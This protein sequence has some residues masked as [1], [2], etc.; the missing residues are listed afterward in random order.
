MRLTQLFTGEKQITDPCLQGVTDRNGAY[1]QLIR[2]LTPG[3]IL[4]GEILSKDGNEVQVRLAENGIL[5]ARLAANMNLEVGKSMTFEVK[6]NGQTLVLSPLFENTATDA[7]VFKALDMASLPVNE[8]TVEMARQLMEAGLPIDKNTL[9]QVYREINVYQPSE[10]S[11]VVDLHRLGLPVNEDNLNQIA[12]YKNMTYQLEQGFESIAEKLPQLISDMVQEGEAKEAVQLV[13]QLFT[14]LFPES[15]SPE[16]LL[17]NLV[18]KAEAAV[19]YENPSGEEL[20]QAVEEQSEGQDFLAQMKKTLEETNHVVIKDTEGVSQK[21]QALLEQLFASQEH[22][23]RRAVKE[24]QKVFKEAFQERFTIRP[25]AVADEKKVEELY[26]RLKSQL[27][28]I[29]HAMETV[30]QSGSEAAKATVNL[31]KNLDFLQQLNQ[32][33]TYVQLPLRLQQSTAHG[34][35]Y[36]F[37]N[38]RHLAEKDGEISALLHLT[39]EHLGPVDVYVAMQAERVSTKFYVRDEEMLDF[40]EAHMELLTKRLEKRGYSCRTEAFLRK[41]EEEAPMGGVRA[42]LQKEKQIPLAQ[43]AFDMRA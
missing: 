5:N 7:N 24:L 38:K 19:T 28:G 31:T 6:N 10:I 36:V 3:Q 12:D 37:T 33:Y 29:F 40:L 21:S 30:G 16:E 34:D 23:A 26:S 13:S 9:Q 39:M 22:H 2:S 11:D 15:E 1:R 4:L 25:E 17:Q 35:L 32:A 42:L 8:G 41:E 20:V 18:S 43:Y 14:Q 27:K